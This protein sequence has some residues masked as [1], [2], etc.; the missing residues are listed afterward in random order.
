MMQDFSGEALTEQNTEASLAF[1]YNSSRASDRVDRHICIRCV[2]L[3]CMQRALL[4][5]SLHV[6]QAYDDRKLSL[7]CHYLAVALLIYL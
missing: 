4:S 6:L 1:S 2:G 7:V 5:S 3:Q